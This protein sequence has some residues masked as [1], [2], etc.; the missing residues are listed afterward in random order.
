MEGVRQKENLEEGTKTINIQNSSVV[1]QWRSV[2]QHSVGDIHNSVK[3]LS[4]LFK[5]LTFKIN[6]SMTSP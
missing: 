6:T 1:Y 4:L 5:V 2:F 3:L